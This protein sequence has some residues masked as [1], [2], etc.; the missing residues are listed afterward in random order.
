MSLLPSFSSASNVAVVGA[1]GGI[2]SAVIKLLSDDPHIAK[3][4]AFSRGARS[5]D[6]PKV[7]AGHIDLEDESSIAA[8]A[9]TA[10]QSGALDLVFVASGILSEGDE[11]RPEKS[12]REIDSIA[13]ARLFVVNAAGPT[14]VA[15]HFLPKLRKGSKTLLAALSARVGSIG[16][17]RLGGWYSYRAS[18]AALNMLLRTLAIEHARQ[19]PES[20]VAGLHPGTVDTDLSRPYTSRTPAHKLF[21]VETSARHLIKVMDQLSPEDTGHTFAWDGTRIDF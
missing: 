6:L 13:L 14:L 5:S 8:A 1:S 10:S 16:D 15:K 21:S 18:K 7:I 2:G 4:Y 17:N 12:M 19:W 11:T 9:I 3:I 20:I